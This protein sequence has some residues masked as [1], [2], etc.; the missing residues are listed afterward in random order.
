[1]TIHLAIK[2]KELEKRIA[3]LESLPKP[4]ALQNEIDSLKSRLDAIESRPKP[5]RKPKEADGRQSA[6]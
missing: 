2:I 1:M 5:G 3:D 4:T 6:T